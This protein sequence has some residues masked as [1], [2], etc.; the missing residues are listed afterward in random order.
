MRRKFDRFSSRSRAAAAGLAA[1]LLAS[2]PGAS[3]ITIQFKFG[4]GGGPSRLSRHLAQE[5][6]QVEG[7]FGQNRAALPT[8]TGP[9]GVPAYRRQA[10]LDLID[11][12][13]KDLDQAIL[14]V[15]E[16]KLAGLEAW[17]AEGFRHIR[18][19]LEAPGGAR[20]AA[21]FSGH[22]GFAFVSN[23]GPGAP[24][25]VD[26]ARSGQLLDQV[27]KVI[28]RL[29]FLADKDDLEVKL[30]VGSTPA[31]RA[32]FRFW[33]QASV[34]GST[35]GPASPAIIRTDGRRDHVLRGLYSYSVALG[36]GPVTEL[37]A[38]DQP[39]GAG[40]VGG[41]GS[42]AS[43]KLDLVNGSSFFCCRFEEKYCH[44]VDNENDCQ[45]H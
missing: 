1:L 25:T 8:V 21:V 16:P 43:E 15:Q 3:G 32:T 36:S 13:G 18:S 41:P 29:F 4:N 40:G 11:A 26:T 42:Q 45:A 19:G 7:R 2:G 9:G 20:T 27:E 17:A 23:P 22:A 31:E 14:R 35:G 6:G 38:S 24:D 34:R 39:G 37:L 33:A 10:V 44:H 30:W 28:G 12:T 5:I